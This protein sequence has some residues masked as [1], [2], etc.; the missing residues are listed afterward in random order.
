MTILPQL[1]QDVLNAA[2]AHLPAAEPEQRAGTQAMR[3][4]G[5]RHPRRTILT[6]GA[7]V[8]TA[9]AATLALLLGAATTPLP[10]YALTRN[11]DGTVTVTVHDLAAAIPQLNAKFARLGIDETVI[12]I[13]RGCATPAG[14]LL[15]PASSL[16]ESLTLTAG[17]KYLLAG[18]R[19]VLAAKQL[20]GGKVGLIFGAVHGQVPS[21]FSTAVTSKPVRALGYRH[22]WS[23]SGRAASTRTASQR[24]IERQTLLLAKQAVVAFNS[25]HK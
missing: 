14:A 3:R 19:G 13:T 17:H 25:T 11:T 22:V 12:P 23:R 15:A 20:H 2:A 5:R 16:N 6:F 24:S 18:W 10:A 4:I 21:C 8:V 1:K 9:V 7:A